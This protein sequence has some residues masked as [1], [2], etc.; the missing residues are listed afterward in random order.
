MR[1]RRSVTLPPIG[2]SSRSLKVAIDLRARGHRRL[3]AG[4]LGQV[5]QRRGHLLGV[6]DRLADAHVDDDLVER[7]TCIGFL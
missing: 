2:M 6:V 5:G 4:D 3:L 1:S 7:G